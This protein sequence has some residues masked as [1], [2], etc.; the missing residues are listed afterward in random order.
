M[1][2]ADLQCP[3]IQKFFGRLA[4]YHQVKNKKR[5]ATLWHRDNYDILSEESFDEQSAQKW[6]QLSAPLDEKMISK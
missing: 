2:S 5:K 3:S 4:K 6:Q 1:M